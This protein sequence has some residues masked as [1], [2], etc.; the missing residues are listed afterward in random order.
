MLPRPLQVK[1]LLHGNKELLAKYE[2]TLLGEALHDSCIAAPKA[3]GWNR[4]CFQSCMLATAT[5][6]QRA[7]SYIDESNSPPA[8][9]HTPSC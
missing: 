2:Q 7:Q 6:V 8:T 5:H 9:T 1:K 3:D 4:T